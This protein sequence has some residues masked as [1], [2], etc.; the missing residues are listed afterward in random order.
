MYRQAEE[1]VLYE[2]CIV[3]LRFFQTKYGHERVFYVRF[4]LFYFSMSWTIRSDKRQLLK[5]IIKNKNA[6]SKYVVAL[7]SSI[8]EHN[9]FYD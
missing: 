2:R 3:T 1:F 8:Y 5:K 6:K 7:I 9:K 4:S